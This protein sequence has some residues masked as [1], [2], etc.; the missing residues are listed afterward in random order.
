M[1]T[2]LLVAHAHE[3][4]EA[5]HFLVK[6][7]F[8]HWTAAGHRVLVH[9]GPTGLPDADVAFV[10]IDSTVI[11]APYLDAL[12]RCRV[13]LNGK[14]ADISKRSFSPN[15]VARADGF[16]GPVIVKTNRNSGGFPEAMHARNAIESG[17]PAGPPVRF[18]RDR[19]P[20]F[21]SACEVPP[22]TWSDPDLVVEKFL[23]EQ[24]ERGYYVRYWVF[25][26][27][28]ERCSRY[29][30]ADP[31][32]KGDRATERVPVEVPAEIR[33]W[34]TRLG[35]DFGKFDFVLH[36]GQ[37]VLLDVNRTPTVPPNLS[38]AVRAQQASLSEG[39]AAFLR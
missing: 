16:T 26:G 39:I 27:D 8:E 23:P 6:G 33:A 34:R 29:L 18:M 9:E 5:R 35:F 13:V 22:S 24:D 20:I 1:A 21:R 31:I 10:H 32:V 30:E 14:T 25:L 12:S 19:Y 17:E 2:I 7:L 11:P 38:D 3:R 37:P 28:R 36:D 4:F 15:V